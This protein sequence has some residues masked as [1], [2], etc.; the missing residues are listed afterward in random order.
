MTQPRPRIP[1]SPL[2]PDEYDPDWDDIKWF[3]YGGERNAMFYDRDNNPINLRQWARATE[4]PDY[5]WVKLTYV[6]NDVSVATTW[7]G[8]DIDSDPA[9]TPRIFGTIEIRGTKNAT[10]HD[11][12][13][14]TT[15]V[16]ALATHDRRVE[17][18]R[19]ELCV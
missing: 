11:E 12:E 17:E 19:G 3:D 7:I 15:E 8:I 5:R 9:K 1:D 16:A 6:G 2:G 10:Y 18:L 14:D 13:T 4:D